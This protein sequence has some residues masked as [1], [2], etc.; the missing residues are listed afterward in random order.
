MKILV[1]DIET[2]G[3]PKDMKGDIKDSSNWPYIVQIS[4]LVYD[5]A[6]KSI[7]S[8]HDHIIKLPDNKQIPIESTKIHGITN[9]KMLNE[10]VSINQILSGTTAAN[11]SDFLKDFK[12]CQI[13]VAH[14]IK[15]DINI[16]QAE[17]FRNFNYN[18]IPDYNKIE[19][20]TMK[21]G[22][23]ITK[24]RRKSHWCDGFYLKPPKLSELHE[25]LF[26]TTPTNLHN[27]MVDVWACFRCFHHM[28][29]GYDIC[30]VKNNPDIANRYK[31]LCGEPPSG[32]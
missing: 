21:Y 16:I 8:I 4:W 14:N 1:I 24:I 29:F 5:D 12:D 22:K 20:C 15:F 32:L 31:R 25:K 27:S 7:T 23:S 2:T 28:V 26:A 13:L 6:I 11:S 18:P 19:Y 30:N 10:G 3:L 9:E 17:I